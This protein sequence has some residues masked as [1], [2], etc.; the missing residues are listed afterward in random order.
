MPIH[1]EEVKQSKQSLLLEPQNKDAAVCESSIQESLVGSWQ[2]IHQTASIHKSF[3]DYRKEWV[4][5]CGQKG[6]NRPQEEVIDTIRS[7]MNYLSG[8]I[9]IITMFITAMM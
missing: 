3:E 4:G 7:S 5:C 6:W 9:I 8:F 2:T 1:R